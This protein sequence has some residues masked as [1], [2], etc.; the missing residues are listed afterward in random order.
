[1]RVSEMTVIPEIFPNLKRLTICLYQREYPWQLKLPDVLARMP[2]LESLTLFGLGYH[3]KDCGMPRRFWT[4][5][6]S[7]R[8]L[9]ELHLLDNAHFR[10]PFDMWCLTHKMTKFTLIE[11]PHHIGALIQML[12]PM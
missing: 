7:M 4:S 5:I 3:M 9:K 6:N 1:R 8:N 11:Y 2:E 10:F 12:G